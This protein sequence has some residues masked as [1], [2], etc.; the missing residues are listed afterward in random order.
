MKVLRKEVPGCVIVAIDPAGNDWRNNWDGITSTPG[1]LKGW[2]AAYMTSGPRFFYQDTIDINGVTQMMEKALAPL[3]IEAQ[4]ADFYRIGGIAD[5]IAEPDT[6]ANEIVMLTTVPFDV[7]NWLRRNTNVITQPA[8]L[9]TIFGGMQTPTI[10][11]IS[12]GQCLFGRFRYLQNDAN[13]FERVA[14]VKGESYFGS[15]DMTM[16]DELYITR[17]IIFNGVVQPGNLIELPDLQ[18]NIHMTTEELS[19]LAKIMELRRSYLT[20]QRN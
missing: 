6:Y 8:K 16:A 3:H 11:A 10:N 15:L 20:Q 17:I 9:P 4:Q 18:L 1:D 5:P 19:D 14:L 7:D 13:T 12:A 2:G